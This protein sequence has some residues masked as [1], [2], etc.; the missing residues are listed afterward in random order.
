MSRKIPKCNWEKCKKKCKKKA[1]WEIGFSAI[2]QNDSSGFLCGDSTV[3]TEFFCDLHLISFNG[4]G[5]ITE[6]R[7]IGEEKWKVFDDYDN[8]FILQDLVKDSY[9]L[10]INE[11]LKFKKITHFVKEI[12]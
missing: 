1:R 6:F 12:K 7:K 8:S 2:I 11:K 9:K 3:Y 5:N 4:C 10:Y